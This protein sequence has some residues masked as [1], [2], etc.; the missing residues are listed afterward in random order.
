MLFNA[1]VNSCRKNSRRKR[2]I[3]INTIYIKLRIE[4]KHCSKC[5]LFVQYTIANSEYEYKYTQFLCKQHFRH[6]K[7][8]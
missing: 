1:E 7:Y 3:E 2:I 4:K 8:E 6:K 5:A